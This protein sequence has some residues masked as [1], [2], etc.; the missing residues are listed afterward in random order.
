MTLQEIFKTHTSAYKGRDEAQQQ[1]AQ[2]LSLSAAREGTSVENYKR[3]M[4][5]LMQLR[6]LCDHPYV[7]N[8]CLP[9]PYNIGEHIVAA[10]SKLIFLDKLLGDL[11][12]KGERVLVF[13]QWTS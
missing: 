6:R 2:A 7:L 5:L 10:S 11:L 1:V 9:E 3:L 4:N 13:S 12:P 8:G